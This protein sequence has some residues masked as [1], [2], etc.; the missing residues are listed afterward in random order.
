MAN[1]IGEDISSSPP[2]FT[3]QVMKTRAVS[4][5]WTGIL[6]YLYTL[7]SLGFTLSAIAGPISQQLVIIVREDAWQRLSSQA[8]RD[9]VIDGWGKSS[10]V[11]L[12]IVR[13]FGTH[14]WVIKLEKQ[15]S[16]AEVTHLIEEIKQDPDIESIEE[17]SRGMILPIRPGLY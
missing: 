4:N 1:T 15:L 17:N 7:V 16:T 14:G 2:F 3:E 13:E 12:S 8:N 10:Q 11:D 9:V 5:L 6:I